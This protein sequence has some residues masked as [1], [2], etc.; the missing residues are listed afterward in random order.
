[1]G[2]ASGSLRLSAWPMDFA[3]VEWATALLLQHHQIH[4]LLHPLLL[5]QKF[6]APRRG[7]RTGAPG[8]PAPRTGTSPPP[9]A[10]GSS[11]TA[12]MVQASLSPAS[13]AWCS[14]RPLTFVTGPPTSLP[15]SSQFPGSL[16][17]YFLD[18]PNNQH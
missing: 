2:T 13:L 17:P 5:P 4:L 15:A 16:V 3:E 11:A 14:T 1:M 9:P 8:W 12:P 6:P 7:P 10:A 18:G